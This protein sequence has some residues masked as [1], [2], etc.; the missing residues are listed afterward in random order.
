MALEMTHFE[1]QYPDRTSMTDP[2]A[3]QFNDIPTNKLRAYFCSLLFWVRLLVIILLLF[4]L[5]LS[6]CY[7]IAQLLKTKLDLII[8]SWCY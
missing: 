8:I 4:L 3:P 1:D 6:G 5:F 2:H 7:C